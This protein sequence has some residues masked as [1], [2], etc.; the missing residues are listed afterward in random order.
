MS[1]PEKI[2]EETPS[3]G[4]LWVMLGGVGLAYTWFGS[5][6][7]RF[8]YPSKGRTMNWQFVTLTDQLRRGDAMLYQ[9]PSG[10]PINIARREE[11]GE[12]TDFV[13]LSSTCP[14]L[15]CQVNWESQ[16]NRFCC[17]CHND[18]QYRSGV[19]IRGQ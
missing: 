8:L 11:A 1:E 13:A 4:V 9:A 15:G 16:H 7:A 6:A 5:F 2:T 19:I 18:E 12:V 14:H 10:E 17:P 3:R